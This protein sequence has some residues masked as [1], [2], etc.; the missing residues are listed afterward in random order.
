M[1]RYRPRVAHDSMRTAS[2]AR[3][4]RPLAI[5]SQNGSIPTGSE[6]TQIPR[7]VTS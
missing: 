7:L 1:V 6:R 4:R 3:L 5:P 2:P